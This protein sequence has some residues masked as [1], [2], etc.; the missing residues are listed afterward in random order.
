MKAI[1]DREECISCGTCVALCPEV[2]EWDDDARSRVIEG[3]DCAVAGC[4]EE[5]AASCPVGAI[6]I[7]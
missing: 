5:A 7:E 6:T 3:A 1:V 4:C 2:F